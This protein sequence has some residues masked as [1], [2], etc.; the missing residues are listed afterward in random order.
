M[1]DLLFI[2]LW[3]FSSLVIIRSLD[4]LVFFKFGNELPWYHRRLWN[5]KGW[6]GQTIWNY[7]KKT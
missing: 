2:L 7:S 4:R 6:G 3:V 5:K 1:S